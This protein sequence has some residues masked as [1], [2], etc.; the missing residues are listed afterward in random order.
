MK[1]ARTSA[2]R[3]MRKPQ[4]GGRAAHVTTAVLSAPPGEPGEAAA[5]RCQVSCLRS[6]AAARQWGGGDRERQDLCKE[7][8]AHPG[9]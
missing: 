1:D 5:A 2:G 6:Q 7:A 9:N 4:R 8:E 3:R